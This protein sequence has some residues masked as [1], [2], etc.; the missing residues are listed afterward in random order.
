[1][2]A[3]FSCL[4]SW[5]LGVAFELPI[6]S[7]HCSILFCFYG[8]QQNSCAYVFTFW[9]G[10]SLNSVLVKFFIGIFMDLYLQ[11]SIPAVR[12]S[13]AEE[14]CMIFWKM[15]VHLFFFFMPHSMCGQ[16]CGISSFPP[17][18]RASSALLEHA[19]IAYIPYLLYFPSISFYQG[20]RCATIFC[21]NIKLVWPLSIFFWFHSSQ[22]MDLTFFA[23]T[24]KLGLVVE[25]RT[26]ETLLD[27]SIAELKGN[28]SDQ[29]TIQAGPSTGSPFSRLHCKGKRRRPL[30]IANPLFFLSHFSRHIWWLRVQN[31][32]NLILF[33]QHGF[34]LGFVTFFLYPQLFQPPSCPAFILTF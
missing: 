15:P 27:R 17:S 30:L 26:L 18:P 23:F 5:R 32:N 29:S 25:N 21:N 19:S 7:F 22:A 20:V 31:R 24:S 13:S 33:V 14:Y 1:V 4:H 11:L 2:Q 3:S 6:A 28:G 12:F 9:F 16:D 8:F 34:L 10:S